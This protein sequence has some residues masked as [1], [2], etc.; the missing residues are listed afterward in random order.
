MATKFTRRHLLKFAGG[1]AAG[2][3][4]TPMP[5]KMLDDLAI[6]TQNGPWIPK[7]PRGEVTTK[8]TT[9][10]LC[11]AGCG[12]RARCVAGQP[13]A[14]SGVPAHP[15]SHGALCP[16]GL[17]GHHLPFHSG[18]LLQPVRLKRGGNDVEAVPVSLDAAIAEIVSAVNA[19]RAAGSNGTIAILDQVPGRTI[20]RLY[21]KF[22]GSV[23]RGIYIAGPT[24]RDGFDALGRMLT[25]P[26]GEAGLDLENAAVLL[27]FGAPV[28]DGWG[29]PGR[30][31]G[32]VQAREGS[33]SRKMKIIQVE[34]RR[35]RTAA[36][37]DVW[38]PVKPGT[39]AALALGIANVLIRE[40][41]VDAKS[42]SALA[43]D[44][45]GPDEFS[46]KA[47]VEKFSPEKTTALTGLESAGI[48][49][50]ARE[51][52]QSQPAVAVG[53]GDPAGGPLGHEEERAIMALNLLLGS[54]GVKGGIVPRPQLPE[55]P[56]LC[57]DAL[58]E[59]RAIEDIED[60]SIRVLITDP[61]R[62]GR[63]LPWKLLERKLAPQGGLVVAVAPVLAGDALR[64][65]L[66]LPSPAFTE[67]IDEAPVPADSPVGT[68]SVAQ[69]LRAA[70]AGVLEPAR[71]IGELATA[72]SIELFSGG[73]QAT[74]ASCLRRKSEAIVKAGRGTV[75]TPQDGK[76]T[77]VAQIPSADAFWKMI[78]EGGCWRDEPSEPKRPG[79][80]T[81]VG[82]R[83]GFETL[84]A[85]GEGRL[86][87]DGADAFPM[88][89][90]PSGVRGALD[91]AN[92]SPLM[93][94]IYQESGLR[95][96]NNQAD[97]NPATARAL[98]LSDRSIALVETPAGGLRVEIRFDSS[99]MP[100]V[101]HVAAGPSGPVRNAAGSRDRRSVLEISGGGAVWRVTRARVR[102]A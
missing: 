41:L 70:P 102:E 35:S 92:V 9:C 45:D 63:A 83:S 5:W 99:V 48:V 42:I 14:L 59:S 12:V 101:V 10:T 80:V 69:P 40:N 37:A 1:S 56:E 29:T 15:V 74:L 36:A 87:A 91:D 51:L 60:G 76:S 24:E 21:R 86:P 62:S 8:F 81:L 17:G 65:Q 11:P 28:L 2:I 32:L 100:G 82:G 77:A 89:L 61:A 73:Q 71:L 95:R 53:G 50:L 49:N 3:L 44:F 46:Y 58:A 97:I 43:G 72:L 26:W 93:T 33:A 94:K 68:F 7:P 16:V 47:L 23:G 55:D 54:V 18:R 25:D 31:A 34:S 27:S 96:L 64:A 52:A 4:L 6:W 57:G 84:V 13:V 20:S 67:G 22:L 30:I 75:F 19:T 66:V 39:E 38:L 90:M 85:A 79:R 88:V 78:G 98:G